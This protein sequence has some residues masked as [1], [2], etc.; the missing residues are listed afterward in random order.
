MSFFQWRR[1]NFFDIAKDVEKGTIASQLGEDNVI[2]CATSGRGNIVL[3]DLKVKYFSI[4]LAIL[5]T[6]LTRVQYGELSTG[7][8]RLQIFLGGREKWRNC[9]S[10]A[11]HHT[12]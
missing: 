1:F 8:G 5:F 12:C 3:G 7:I 2:T 10:H 11:S 6:F 9:Y 4:L